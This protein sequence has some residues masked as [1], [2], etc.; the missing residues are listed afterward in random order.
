MILVTETDELKETHHT[1]ASYVKHVTYG[2]DLR[3]TCRRW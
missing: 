1:V 2:D 3:D